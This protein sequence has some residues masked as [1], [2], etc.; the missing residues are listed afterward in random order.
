MENKKPVIPRPIHYFFLF[1]L[2]WKAAFKVS[3]AAVS[4][5]LRFF[6]YFVLLIGKVFQ[7]GSIAAAA[8][9]IPVTLNTVYKLVE[10][11]KDSFIEYVVCPKC[12]SIYE[13]SDC[14]MVRANGEKESKVCCHVTMPNHPHRLQRVPCGAVLLKKQ[15]TK[16]RVHLT[17]IKVYP[18]RPLKGSI[19]QLLNRP[20]ILEKC[21]QWRS[22][23]DKVPEEYLGDIYDGDVWKSFNST[24]HVNFLATPYSYLLT[25]NVDWFQPF[26]HSV[27]S[28]GAIY[29]TIQNLPR[30]DRYKLEN[31]LLTGIMPGPKEPKLTVNGFLTPLIEELKQFWDGVVVP[32][33]IRDT[34]VHIHVR[35][36]L[37]CVACDIPASR[38]VCGFVGHNARL[39]CNK[40]LKEFKSI[41][42][43]NGHKTDFSGFDRENWIMRN[44]KLHRE[45]CNKLFECNTLSALHSAEST[46]GVRYSVLLS[47]PYFDPIKF[48]VIDPMHNL[49][50]GTGKHVFK[51]WVESQL[52][53]PENLMLIEARFKLFRTPADVGRLPSN[54]SS[55]Y[56]GFTA[57]QWCN[58]I[59]IFS[60]VLLKGI[61][62]DTHLR[63]WLLFVRAC[64]ILRSRV[65]KKC[66]AV[67]A[68]LFLHQFC[69]TF[70]SLYGPSKCTPNTHLHLHLK[71]CILDFGPLHAFWCYA[72]ERYNGVLGS[73][74]T[75]HK[76]IESQLM[77]R[78]CREQELNSLELPQDTEF[79]HLLPNSTST[80]Q[81]NLNICIDDKEVT[82]WLKLAHSQLQNCDTN[83][84]VVNPSLIQPLPPFEEKVL[85]F[86][87]AKELKSLYQQLYPRKQIVHM[88]VFYREYGRITLAGDI[89]GSV[90]RGCNSATSAVIMAYWPGS[91]HS[92]QSI[93]YGRMRVGVVQYFLQH[94]VIVCDGEHSSS[95]TLSHLLCY[96]HWKQIHPHADWCG[97]S[98]TV[99]SDLFET[100]DAC[101]FMP[102]QRIGFRCAYAKLPMKFPTHEETVFVACPIPLKY[103]I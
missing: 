84:F 77:R 38:K 4:S 93:D 1:I 69:Q 103:S 7:S 21:E 11:N 58:W 85:P 74:H 82:R 51:I 43:E 16:K 60:P 30:Q 8:D 66:D 42:C 32:V 73:M 81:Q 45:Q 13:Y 14:V 52:L 80:T 71:G 22:R 15:R 10:V 62:P 50:L 44:S 2:L 3:N 89:V 101:C 36:A 49:F 67:S 20:G 65:I 19:Q 31:I 90:K 56:G 59:T 96:I 72:F 53:T 40:C 54:I 78:F 63:S 35:L 27:Y 57:N 91:G 33:R 39:G 23:S 95:E 83:L 9:C 18:Y 68:D 86:T 99:C 61:L 5:L 26:T 37:S 41:P 100:P 79:L 34:I 92:L 70:Q 28:T 47:L 97:I 76:S 12:G 87:H 94:S 24:E 25:L 102:V 55:G 29:L 46:Y 75:N 98:A 88:P 64:S 6:K 48:T 17:P